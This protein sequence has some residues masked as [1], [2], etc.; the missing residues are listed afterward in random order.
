MKN[1]SSQKKTDKKPRYEELE[2]RINTLKKENARLKQTEQTLLHQS[3]HQA[4]LNSEERYLRMAENALDMICRMGLPDGNY[5]YVSPAS[6]QIFGYTPEQIYQSKKIILKAIHPEFKDFFKKA[7]KRLEKGQLPSFFEYKIIHRDGNI[8]WL[9]QRNVLIRDKQGNPVAVEGIIT[10]VT[11]RKQMEQQLKESKEQYKQLSDATFEAIFLL[12]K[13]HCISQNKSAQEMFGYSDQEAFGK[14]AIE[15][16]H[17]DYRE[18]AILESQAKVIGIYQSLAL[19]KDQTT[20]PCEIQTRKVERNG[21]RIRIIALRDI[22]RQIKAEQEKITAQNY[23]AEQAKNALVGEIAG[24]MAHDFNNILGVIMGNVQLSMVDCKDPEIYKT[25]ELIF[26]QT[27]RG[28][29][30]TRNLVVFA[31]DQEPKQEYFSINEKISLVTNLLKKD[32]QNIQIIKDFDDTLPELL[33]DPGMIEHALVNLVQNSIHALSQTLSPQISL[34][35]Y[36]RNKQICFEI[37]DNGCGIP[38]EHIDDIFTPSFT[39]KG[40]KDTKKCYAHN[41]KGTG[42]GMTNVKRYIEQH[43]GNIQVFSTLGSGTRFFISLPII[44]KQ[45]SQ[46]EQKIIQALH[47]QTGKRVLI[48]EDEPAI[49]DVQYR[50]LSSPPFHH[51]VDLAPNGRVAMDLFDRN[52]YDVISLDYLLPGKQNGMDIYHY[53]R[54]TNPTIPILFV[55]GNIEF[56]ESI[57]TLK[58]QDPC[59]DH[60]SKPCQ[61]MTYARSIHELIDHSLPKACLDKESS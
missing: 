2:A 33:A 53:I 42:Y 7:W 49:S 3:S 21:H 56:L 35:T 43:K 18:Q 36:T 51:H 31:K 12:E 29:N 20:F 8:R 24:K 26:D 4:F 17:P 34:K 41:I 52:D 1:N 57:K 15:W 45:L 46:T 54:K 10:D 55:S 25:L 37:M 48:V 28:K 27:L 30:L 47:P 13:G 19:R 60:L 5:E 9:N 32:L 11:L 6:K 22:T 40:T 44:D 14:P 23:A 38:E 58:Q 61:N 16:I 50:I 39:L 59:I